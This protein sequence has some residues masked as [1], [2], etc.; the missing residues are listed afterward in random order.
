MLH[1]KLFTE[2]VAECKYLTIIISPHFLNL[3]EFKIS[4]YDSEWYRD[5]S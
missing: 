4:S 5:S 2:N 1:N 3:V